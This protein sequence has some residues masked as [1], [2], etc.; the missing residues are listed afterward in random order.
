MKDLAVLRAWAGDR[1]GQLMDGLVGEEVSCETT[2][3]RTGTSAPALNPRCSGGER[4]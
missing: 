4:D 2:T 1:L 3:D